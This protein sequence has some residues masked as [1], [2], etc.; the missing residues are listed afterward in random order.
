MF[1][2]YSAPCQHRMVLLNMHFVYLGSLSLYRLHFYPFLSDK[3][4]PINQSI[5]FE[6]FLLFRIFGFVK[7]V[8]RKHDITRKSMYIYNLFLL[9]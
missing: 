2:R 3:S 7:Q 9:F 8:I 1:I 4:T 5:H 6:Y